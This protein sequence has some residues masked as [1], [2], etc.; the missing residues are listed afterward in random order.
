MM[1]FNKFQRMVLVNKKMLV[2]G[3]VMVVVG[4]ILTINISDTIPVGQAGMTDEE[5]LDLMLAEQENEDYNTLAGILF[6]LGFLLM[7]ISF[8][9]RKKKGKPVKK[10]E[11][12]IE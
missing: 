4:L 3:M 2:G 10:V 9:A 5:K 7:L 11:K 6:G 12:K 1:K 8:G